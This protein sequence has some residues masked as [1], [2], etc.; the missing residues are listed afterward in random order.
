MAE[1][2]ASPFY[3][4]LDANGRPISGAT[5]HFYRTGTTTPAS[6]YAGANLSTAL[7]AVVTADSAGRFVPIYLSPATTYRAILKDAQGVTIRETDPV[8]PDE[9]GAVD[10]AAFGAVYNSSTDS[11]AAFAAAMASDAPEILISGRVSIGT[12]T[13]LS[14]P[15]TIRCVGAGEIVV[16]DETDISSG[17]L[18][19][20]ADDCD[21]FLRFDGNGKGSTG[22]TLAGDRNIAYVIGRDFI[23]SSA[24]GGYEALVVVT[25]DNNTVSVEGYD[26]ALGGGL[27]NNV[28]RL[29]T[30]Q[31]F[32]TGTV[33]PLMKG[34]NIVAGLTAASHTDITVGQVELDTLYDNGFYLLGGCSNVTVNGGRIENT[35]EPAVIAGATDVHFNGLLVVNSGSFGL[36]SATRVYFNDCHKRYG[37]NAPSSFVSTRAD[38]VTSTTVVLNNCSGGFA[39]TFGGIAQFLAGTVNDFRVLGGTYTLTWLDATDATTRIVR[40][41]AG[42][43]VIYKDVTVEIIDGKTTPMTGSNVLYWELPSLSLDSIWEDVTVIN[44]TA[45]IVRVTP[46]IQA[47]LQLRTDAYVR[48]DLSPP[49]LQY[50]AV[51]AFPTQRIVTSASVPAQGTWALG[52]I[53]FNAAP[54]AGGFAGWICTAAGTPGTWKTFM[55]ISA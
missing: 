48:A 37:S 31:G 35:T 10:L 4:A 8:N 23:G 26:F 54:A 33:I 47:K 28:P 21:L 15:K 11:T 40:H 34:R 17:I 6:V 30:L 3:T 22:V 51:G 2:F 39:P 44:R 42:N 32:G 19:V 46:I 49:A 45:A 25:G 52:D 5:L 50:F 38:N 16:R 43:Q 13:V 1:L 20:T 18:Y 36:Q 7:G 27:N 55:P 41:S 14:T 53:V 12:G 9:D 29:L 24:S